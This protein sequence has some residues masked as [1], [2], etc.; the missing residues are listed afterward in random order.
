MS[1]QL[2]EEDYTYS[3]VKEY[4]HYHSIFERVLEECK[5]VEDTIS[6]KR[7]LFDD[8]VFYKLPNGGMLGCWFR[9]YEILD[10]I[11]VGLVESEDEDIGVFY[12]PLSSLYYIEDC[13]FFQ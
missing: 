9:G 4:L 12:S 8:Y 7:H 11:E 5:Y 6:Y 3:E 13:Y 2:D 10:G 1:S